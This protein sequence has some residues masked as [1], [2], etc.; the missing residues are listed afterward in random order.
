MIWGVKTMIESIEFENWIEGMIVEHK[1]LAK[2]M[3]DGIEETYEKN[4]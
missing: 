4:D 1:E 2:G 3:A